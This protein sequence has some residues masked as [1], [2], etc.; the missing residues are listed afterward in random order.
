MIFINNFKVKINTSDVYQKTGLPFIRKSRFYTR[1]NYSTTVTYLY[2]IVSFP[3][4]STA[5]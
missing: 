3:L 2:I 4:E 5:S 1:P